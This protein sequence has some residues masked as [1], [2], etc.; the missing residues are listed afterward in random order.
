M[1]DDRVDLDPALAELADSRGPLFAAAAELYPTG[2]G[3]DLPWGKR[4]ASNSAARWGSL[5]SQRVGTDWSLC[6]A[7][8]RS[9][10]RSRTATICP[11]STMQTR[12][13]I[14]SI[15]ASWWLEMS[16]PTSSSSASWRRV[17]RSSL[18]PTGS[19]PLVGSSKISSL[20]R[21]RMAWAT[22]S[23]CRIPRE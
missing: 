16:T 11:A 20:G 4:A 7:A 22:P 12:S 1:G 5:T 13:H 15:S 21:W 6:P 18:M 3:G 9:A 8:L 10:R 19:R 17:S 14:S 23:R 2:G